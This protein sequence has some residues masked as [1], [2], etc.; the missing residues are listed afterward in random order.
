MIIGSTVIAVARAPR[1]TR[2]R[3]L[4]TLLALVASAAATLTPEVGSAR[5]C[6]RGIELHDRISPSVVRVAASV[7]A[8]IFAPPQLGSG[9]AIGDR[10]IVTADHVVADAEKVWVLAAAESR[11]QA[12]VVR[13]HPEVDLALLEWPDSNA[14]SALPFSGDQARAGQCVA[15]LGNVMHAGIGIFCGMVSMVGG[16]EQAR[17]GRILTDIV[18]PPG[19]SG[20]ALVDCATGSLLG[21]VTFGLVDL[22][23]PRDTAGIISAVPVSL[24]MEISRETIDAAVPAEAPGSLRRRDARVER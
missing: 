8:N 7:G 1:P 6:E 15:A 2:S 24:L 23:S 19:L 22:S 3:R 12:E 9:V 14:L 17:P 13:R 16:P 10:L 11:H 5:S 20:G 21:I 18:A 4:L